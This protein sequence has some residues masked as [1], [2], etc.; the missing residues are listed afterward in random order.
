[1]ETVL[2]VD[3]DQWAA[4]GVLAGWRC[5]PFPERGGQYWG[6]PADSQSAIG[7]L[8]RLRRRGARFIAFVWP[9]F[10]WLDYYAEFHAY[11]LSRSRCLERNDRLVLF[12]LGL[13]GAKGG[14]P[15]VSMVGK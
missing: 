6:R 12:D 13:A 3:E 14:T 7:E 9:A 1:G 8:E 15:I 4:E 10:W 5:L 2:L 11:L